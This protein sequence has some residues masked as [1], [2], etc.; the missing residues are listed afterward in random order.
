MRACP[1]CSRTYP[2]DTDFCPRDGALLRWGN[3]RGCPRAATGAAPTQERT[4]DRRSPLQ[5][6][7]PPLIPLLNRGGEREARG[8]E[9]RRY[10]RRAEDLPL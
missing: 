2:D 4:G 5:F 6:G 3:P 10:N 8:G 1:Q 7:V 9:Q